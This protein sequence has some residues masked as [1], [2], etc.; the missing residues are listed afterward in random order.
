MDQNIVRFHQDEEGCWVAN[1][2]CG[3]CQHVRHNPPWVNRP[4]IS[5]EATREL[6]IG[7]SLNC[8]K[9]NMP[10]IPSSAK[11]IKCSEQYDQQ[12]LHQQFVGAQVNNSDFWIKVIIFEGELVY[13]RLTEIPHGYVVDSE[14]SA[15]IEPRMKYILRSKG[16]VRFKFQY[17]QVVEC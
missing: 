15:V 3:H 6:Y 12:S 9:C 14:Y 2:I 11:Q 7:Q 5:T 4:W 17:Y 1:L 10:N 8:L 13:R 16:P